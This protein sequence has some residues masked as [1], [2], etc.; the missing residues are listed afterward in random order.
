M[1][2]KA[3]KL[4]CVLLVL[5][6]CICIPFTAFAY[7]EEGVAEASILQGGSFDLP[8]TAV[9]S[10]SMFGARSTTSVQDV[11]YQGLLDYNEEINISF[12]RIP[13][14]S[15][16]DLY[17]NV[18]N[19]H[20]DLF[21]VSS[22]FSYSYYP[23]NNTVAVII[24]SYSMS[25]EEIER[26]KA[27]FN[28]GVEKALSVVDD[29]MNDVQ[30]A[31]VIHDYMCDVGTYPVLQFDSNGNVLNDMEIYHS[32]FGFFYDGKV[33]CAGY[34]LA[35]SYLM[36]SLGIQ[37]E[38]VAS[39]S[40]G[41]AW[42]IINIDN[43]W[44]HIDL[45]YDDVYNF[46]ERENMRGAAHHRCFMKSDTAIKGNMGYYHYGYSTYDGAVASDTTYD[47]YFWNEVYT[48]IPVING[49]YYYPEFNPTTKYTYMTKRTVDGAVS[50]VT[51]KNF[52]S[53]SLNMSGSY[54]DESGNYNTVAF[55]E[56]LIR[57]AQLDGRMYIAYNEYIYSLTPTGKYY[58][59]CD[60]TN[61]P[62]GFGVQDGSL[63]YQPYSTYT[64]V[65]VDKEQYLNDYFMTTA[66]TTENTYGEYNNYPDVNYD[67]IVNTVDFAL[68]KDVI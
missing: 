55:K 52:N 20:P 45:T 54:P 32:A 35:Y 6:L 31:L 22:T 24:P 21:Y 44:Y 68:S 12:F 3:N 67:G 26:N 56:P 10:V 28:E 57:V 30:K 16:V 47:D 59:I 60:M 61:Y 5:I 48:M 8:Q 37:C 1:N 43:N 11:I 9:A 25:A 27:I 29:S 19:D 42:N 15:L 23:S 13:V 40:M 34:T 7:T 49:V 14:S 65:I 46:N 58:K 64:P 17:S 62:V 39:N 66:D 4:I 2:K 36:E 33:V 63:V 53:A 51:T 18:V 50:K 41:H 38:Y